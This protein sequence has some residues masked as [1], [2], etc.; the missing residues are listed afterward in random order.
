[1]SR[2]AALDSWHADWSG[3]NVVVLGLGATGFAVADTLWELGANALVIDTAVSDEHRAMLDALGVEVA[4]VGS[5]AEV[6]ERTIARDPDVVIVNDAI[7]RWHPALVA[8]MAKGVPIWNDIELA[9]RVRDKTRIARWIAVTGTN[10]KTE[11]ANLTAHFLRESGVRAIPVGA[12]ETPVLDAVRDPEGFDVFV[13]ELSSVQLHWLPTSGLGALQPFA[14]VCLNVANEHLEWHESADAYRAV[15][16]K[17]FHNTE[18]AVFYNRGDALTEAL[19]RDAEVI[20][21]CE[22]IG[23]G[24]LVPDTGELGTIDGILVD[25]A[26]VPDRRNTAQELTTLDRLAERGL[27]RPH[28]IL[29]ILAASG[30][31]LAAG[32]S[33]E[34]IANSLDAFPGEPHCDEVV[35]ENAGITWINN[36]KAT[37][38]HAANASLLSYPSIVWIVGGTFGDEPIDDLI[39]AHASRI[40]GVIAI[41]TDRSIPKSALVRLAPSIP[42]VEITDGDVMTEAVAAAARIAEAGDTVLFAP[43]AGSLDQFVDY[44]DRGRRF[45]DAVT[46]YIGGDRGE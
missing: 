2:A 42:L 43:A 3:L 19:V 18:H 7:S 16:G 5:D 44:R 40:R 4:V 27:A 12:A 46:S 41:G 34:S 11:T 28:T 24:L 8:A 25:R 9:W 36:S 17:V 13:V 6:A 30:L 22:A 35:A 20:E 37:N 45:V 23:F 33:P 32:A 38:P 14:S 1:M 29:N 39:A 26:F 31:A 10:G 15:K 21:G